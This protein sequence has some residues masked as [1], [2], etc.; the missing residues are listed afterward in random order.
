MTSRERVFAALERKAPDRIPHFEWS[1]A[2]EVVQAAPVWPKFAWGYADLI[3]LL[4]IDAVVAWDLHALKQLSAD[5]FLDD[6]GITRRIGK[7]AY[8]MAA[9]EKAPIREYGDLK[10]YSFADPGDEA[11]YMMLKGM[12]RRFKGERAIVF[13]L[14]DVYSWPRELRGF[15]ALMADILEAPDFVEE[16]IIKSAEYVKKQARRAAELGAEIIMTGDDIATN[17]GLLFSPAHFR[18]LFLPHYRDLVSYIKS[19]GLYVIKHTDGNISDVAQDIV[20]AGIDCLDPIDPLGGLSL[21]EMRAKFGDRV[22][23]KGNVGCSAVLQF[24][25]PDEVKAE[26]ERCILDAGTKGFILSS[27]NSIHSGIPYENYAALTEAARDSAKF[28]N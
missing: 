17:T 22:A 16:L 23:L 26:A 2:E 27:S 25:T 10:K 24:G 18:K 1:I 15:E 14:R 5:I 12:V 7:E 11:A 6:C 3:E 28:M 19:L 13:K 8:G 20:D 21:S 9:E 4:D